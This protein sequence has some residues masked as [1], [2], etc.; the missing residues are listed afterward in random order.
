M[1]DPS[2]AA[3][4]GTGSP[5]VRASCPICGQGTVGTVQIL[6]QERRP[7]RKPKSVT[8]ASK[9]LCEKHAAE[10]YQGL[11]GAWKHFFEAADVA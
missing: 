3:L 6:L 1:V 8:S 5:G 9:R 10:L 4:R 7:G 11:D 2:F